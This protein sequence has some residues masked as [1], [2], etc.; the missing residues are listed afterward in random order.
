M[1]G[2]RRSSRLQIVVLVV[3]TCLA[4][5]C[6]APPRPARALG[7]QR[8][9]DNTVSDFLAG[10]FQGT[11]VSLAEVT[12]IPGQP[13][14]DES[15]AVQ[16]A[17]AGQ[18]Y[19]PE[20]WYYSSPH[21]L[22]GSPEI[23]RISWTAMITQGAVLSDVRLDYRLSMAADCASPTAFDGAV[24]QTLDASPSPDFF[25]ENGV[26]SVDL[27]GGLTARCLQYR[28]R[29]SS[30]NVWLTPLLLNTSVLIDIA[31]SPDLTAAAAPRYRNGE[32]KTLTWLDVHVRNHNSMEP[33]LPADI[34]APGSFFVDLLVFG[35]GETPIPPTI[36]LSGADLARSK[37]YANL[38]KRDLTVDA[39]VPVLQWFDSKTEQP[40]NIVS[41]FKT[42]GIYNVFVVVDSF[43]YVPEGSLGGENNNIVP[44]SFEVQKIGTPLVFLPMLAYT[45]AQLCD[46]Y[47]PNDKLP[48]TAWG[49]LKLGQTYQAKICQRDAEDNYYF[50]GAANQRVRITISVPPK[51][52]NMTLVWVHA[53]YQLDPPLEFCSAAPVMAPTQSFTCRLPKDSR[54]YVRVYTDR[55]VYDDL[56]PYSLRV[57]PA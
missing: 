12:P 25:S 45:P 9:L 40:T 29:L 14:V 22:G 50:Q 2:I 1:I 13:F 20:G 55:G 57:D 11:A 32:Q 31:G 48:A 26:N 7:V 52:Q 39:N 35:P 38:N 37:A 3:G 51:L 17:N 47:E 53:Q 46:P 27:A 10:S 23:Q 30:D 43:A 18:S 34:A 15:G 42:P 6:S 24:W 56:R 41:F 5:A 4:L 36:P 16:L 44:L 54:Y 49:P 8:L 33:T 19:V 21:S 28:A